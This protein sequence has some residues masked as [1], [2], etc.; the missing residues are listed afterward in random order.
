MRG[1]NAASGLTLADAAHLRQ[2][3]SIILGTPLGSRVMR[4]EFGSLLPALV[5]APQNE[6]TTVRLYAA[7]VIALQRWEPR[8]AISQISLQY[9]Q[10]AQAELLIEGAYLPPGGGEQ[11]VALS[12]PLPGTAA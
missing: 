12:L 5:D 3:I 7:A 11:A 2:S 4:R 9:P 10:P 6:T 1:M 8:L